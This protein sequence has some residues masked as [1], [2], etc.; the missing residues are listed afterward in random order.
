VTK[1][2][3]VL[4]FH[5]MYIFRLSIIDGICMTLENILSEIVYQHVEYM[6]SGHSS[7]LQGGRRSKNLR[8]HVLLY[9]SHPNLIST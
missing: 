6:G 4:F 8:P 5:N 7:I 1:G 3:F 9:L 2:G